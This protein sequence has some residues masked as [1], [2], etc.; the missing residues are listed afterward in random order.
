MKFEDKSSNLFPVSKKEVKMNYMKVIINFD[1]ET[2]RLCV[3]ICIPLFINYS[4]RDILMTFRVVE[5]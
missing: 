5:L 2:L 4:Q 3:V 1:Y